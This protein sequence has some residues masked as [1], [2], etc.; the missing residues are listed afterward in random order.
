MPLQRYRA[1]RKTYPKAK[2]PKQPA[3]YRYADM[4][5]KGFNMAMKLKQLINVEQKHVDTTTSTTNTYNGTLVTFNEIAQGDT[6]NTRDGDSLLNKKINIKGFIVAAAS[7]AINDVVRIIIFKD[8]QNT[9]TTPGQYLRDVGSIYAPLSQKQRD[10][11]FQTKKI[12]DNT[13]S[14]DSGNPL[15]IFS[16]KIDQLDDHTNFVS[17]TTT[18][19]SGAYKM[20]IIGTVA[21]AGAN[22]ITTYTSRFEYIDN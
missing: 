22:S 17:G 20:L 5:Y 4:A 16:I 13:F 6:D 18:I 15:K 12:Y 7:G 19:T 14:V 21:P 8:K 10:N 1:K 11:Q 2:K 9:I 3:R